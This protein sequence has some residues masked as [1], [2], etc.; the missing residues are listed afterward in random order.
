MQQISVNQINV[1]RNSNHDGCKKQ[2]LQD[3]NYQPDS[4]LFFQILNPCTNYK[5]LYSMVIRPFFTMVS[6][7]LMTPNLECS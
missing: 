2:Q 6:I 7:A 1:Q 4:F 3:G 5:F